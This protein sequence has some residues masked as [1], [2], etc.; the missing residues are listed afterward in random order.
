MAPTATYGGHLELS[1]FAHLTQRDVKVIQPGLVYVIEWAAGGNLS[2]NRT[3]PK[4][5]LPEDDS[6]LDDREKRRL[7]RDQKRTG[8]GKTDS[9]ITTSDR[10]P[11]SSGD[12][13]YV[14]YVPIRS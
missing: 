4:E 12:V 3:A 10:H 8:K 1:A 7:R 5:L 13:I 14:A 6:Q 11:E 9:T 2:P